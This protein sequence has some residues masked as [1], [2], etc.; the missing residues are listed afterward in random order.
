M[1]QLNTI[2]FEGHKIVIII[3]NNNI[4]WF[5]AKQICTALGYKQPRKVISKVVDNN[6]KIQLKNMNITFTIQQQPDS[7]YITESG[8]YA[9]L[10]SS[11]TKKSKKFIKWITSEVMPKLRRSNIF[12]SD[13]EITK[14]LKKINELETKNKI[15][16]NDLK[17][18]RFPEGAMVY[19]IEETDSMGQTY[20]RIGKT[21]NMNK[22]IEVYNT[23]S[24]HKKKVVYYVEIL[25]PLQLETCIRA[26]LYKY[27]YKDRKDYYMCD[28]NKIKNAFNKCIESIKCIE[29]K[30][31]SKKYYKITYYEE[32]LKELYESINITSIL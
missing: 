9:V 28:L 11:R 26:M 30:G 10:I 31:G 22:R 15:L 12:S 13:K 27:R 19:V 2:N 16:N 24:V 1:P 29:Q 5:N 32:K 4:I 14:L 20:Y 23:H 8:I 25:C 21:N 3:D 17:M 6:E 7:I 18:E